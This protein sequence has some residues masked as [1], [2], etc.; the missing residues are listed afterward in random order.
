MTP[1]HTGTTFFTPTGACLPWFS[2]EVSAFVCWLC[3]VCCYTWPR[4]V[5]RLRVTC[6]V[7][8][9]VLP[10]LTVSCSVFTRGIAVADSAWSWV[11]SGLVM[12][13]GR[14]VWC[15]PG[16]RS[17]RDNNRITLILIL[18]KNTILTH[19]LTWL[20]AMTTCMGRMSNAGYGWVRVTALAYLLY[21][22]NT[23]TLW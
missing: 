22:F 10:G 6:L 20:T 7:V 11:W 16:A 8:C 5:S 18:W 4:I 15:T 23:I 9:C 1:P 3:A 17:G 19:W 12:R 14:V 13:S 21:V 2:P